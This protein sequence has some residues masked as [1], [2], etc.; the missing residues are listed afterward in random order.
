MKSIKRINGP[1]NSITYRFTDKDTVGNITFDGSNFIFDRPIKKDIPIP[2]E[3]SSINY[4]L[5]YNQAAL[6]NVRNISSSTDWVVPTL[7]NYT[8]LSNYITSTFSVNSGPA[9]RTSL[10]LS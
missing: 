6:T 8:D 7:S 2:P 1:G 3:E 5:L 10:A 4:G 9:L